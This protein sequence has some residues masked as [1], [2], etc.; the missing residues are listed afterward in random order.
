[1]TTGQRNENLDAAHHEEKTELGETTF[2]LE[3]TIQQLDNKIERVVHFS[4][5]F[6]RKNV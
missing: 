3:E 5:K 4:G 6:A 1:M 2:R